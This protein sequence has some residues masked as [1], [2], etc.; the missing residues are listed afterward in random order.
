MERQTSEQVDL[1]RRRASPGDPLPIKYGPIEINEDAP[2][3]KEIQLATSELSNSRAAGASGMRAKH[4]K[5]WLWG[6]RWEEDA[7]GQAPPS[8]GDN[9]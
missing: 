9:W 3:D 1:Y 8:D 2:L 5:D 4:V 6:V 7:K